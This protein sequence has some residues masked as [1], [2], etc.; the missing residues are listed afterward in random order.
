MRGL[1][2]INKLN[3]IAATQ[4]DRAVLALVNRG[5]SIDRTTEDPE[6]F[7]PL[8]TVRGHLNDLT[9]DRR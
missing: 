4:G 6:D 3:E 7:H 5:V 9:P 8:L 1:K 2:E